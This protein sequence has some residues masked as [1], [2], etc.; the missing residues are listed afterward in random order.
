MNPSLP[1]REERIVPNHSNDVLERLSSRPVKLLVDG[2]WV[3]GSG[4]PFALV[5]PSTEKT[6]TEYHTASAEDVDAAVRAARSAFAGPWGQVSPAQRQRLL[7]RLATLVEERAEEFAEAEAVNTGK[8][9][10]ATLRFE[11][12]Q[13]V[14]ILRYNA[15]WATKLNGETRDV[16][17]PGQWHAF[18]QRR[19]IGVAG[20][21]VPWNGP[22]VM[23]C[24]KL[25]AA[26]A[27]GCTAVVK[28]SELTPLTA[29]ML[30]DLAAQA[31]APDGT[32]NVVPGFGGI[33]GEALATHPMVGKVSFTGSTAVGQHLQRVTADHMPRLSLELGGKSPVVI[34]EDADLDRAAHS[35]ALSIF[36]NAGQVCAAGSRLFVQASVADR[37]VDRIVEHAQGIRL[38]GS[39]EEGSMMGPVVSQ[40]QQERVLGY[41]EEGRRAGAS[42]ATGGAPLERLGYFVQ[43]TVLTDVTPR[44]SVVREEIFGPVLTVQTFEDEDQVIQQANDS[45][46]GLSSYVWTQDISRALGTAQRLEAGN[47]RVN[48]HV[49][50]DPTMPFGGF[51]SS[52]YGKENGR[53]GVEAFTELTSV[54]IHL[55]S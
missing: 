24:A 16:S 51:R 40:I 22:F 37:V 48:S 20:L 26:L 6:F 28:P 42:V 19:P 11:I 35:A 41:I 31:G 27:A 55:G 30:G 29:L 39:L 8:P 38:G 45:P 52:G 23:T 36:S 2:Q 18:T 14:E 53:E 54:A 32:V 10:Q 4:E 5:D 43:P 1:S 44:M 25:G 17:L 13:A 9:L 33:A 7:L 15:G 12:P 34:Y 21:I 46:F 3:E 47:V 50:M 49:G